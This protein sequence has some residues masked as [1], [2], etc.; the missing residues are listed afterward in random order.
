M[1]T[2]YRMSRTLAGP[3]TAP[4][5]DTFDGRAFY[6]AKTASDGKRRFAFGWVPS[7]TGETDTGTWN[8][9]GNLVAHEIFQQ[10][11]GSLTVAP[12]PEIGDFFK[13]D[14]RIK[15]DPLIG[16]WKIQGESLEVEALDS[17]AWCRLGSVSW[18]SSI[19]LT[20]NLKEGTRSGGLILQADVGLDSGYLAR[21]EAGRQRIIFE[22]FPRPGDEP[23]IIERPLNLRNAEPIHIQALIDDS[24]IVIY[25]NNE[26]ALS[27]RGYEHQAGDFGVFVSEGAASFADI[28]LKT[29]P[30]T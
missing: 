4:T 28:A 17:F 29:M 25:V 9:G 26:I 7:R 21:I 6:A 20:L 23:P 19:E 12:P 18:A 2:H 14:S 15:P 30:T 3:W 1:V 11:D 5:N 10:A 13:V 16:N 22:R 8:W 27:T 24:V